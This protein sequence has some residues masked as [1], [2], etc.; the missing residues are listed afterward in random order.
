MDIFWKILPVALTVAIP[1]LTA[2]LCELIHKAAV[3]AAVRAKNERVEAL[4]YEIESAVQSA[5]RYVNQTFVDE[6]KDSGVFDTDE[7]YA[8][9]AFKEAYET[10]VETISTDA[11]NWLEETFGD[12]RKYL[13]VRIEDCVRS[14]K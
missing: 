1:V 13:E 9:E 11:L 3:E 5:V 12:I 2:F 10:A 6:L 8:K 7:T 14:V 4:V